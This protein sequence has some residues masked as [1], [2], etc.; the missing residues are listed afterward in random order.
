MF[1]AL[2]KSRI[3]AFLWLQGLLSILQEISVLTY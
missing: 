3:K 2:D 1:V